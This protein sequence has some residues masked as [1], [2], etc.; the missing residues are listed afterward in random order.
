[1]KNEK[2]LSPEEKW[3]QATLANNFIFYKVMRHHPDECRQL[4]EML[5]DINIKKMELHEEDYIDLDHDA[6]GIRPDVF[7][8]DESRIYDIEL[9]VADTGELSERARY[10]QG[11]MDLDT[12]KSGQ[13]YKE[14]KDSHVIFICM[15]DVFKQGLPIYTFENICREDN[16]TKL[17]DR[18]YKHF[19]IA[20]TC[21]KI[22]ENK[23]IKT[24]FDFLVTNGAGNSFTSN[25]K[26]Y[27]DHAKHN[28]Q[29]RFQ[30]MTYE[31]IQ[32][33]AYDK[34]KKEGLTQKAVETAENLLKMGLSAEQIVEATKLTLEQV[35]SLKNDFIQ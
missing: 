8:R 5:L 23:E 4:I 14:L 2:N 28:M 35:Q 20:P 19:F 10:Y 24:F 30:Y 25:L 27:V 31:R 7:I 1:M 26:T 11:L 29:W 16:R 34:G 9:Q 6:K 13:H 3:E 32:A 22:A 21:A 18:T 15:E 12:L 33:Y 17:C